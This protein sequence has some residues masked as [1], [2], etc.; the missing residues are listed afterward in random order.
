M[1]MPPQWVRTS[2]R[3][4]VTPSVAMKWETVAEASYRSLDDPN[5]SPRHFGHVVVSFA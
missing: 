3:T 1:L 2:L 5:I 4:D